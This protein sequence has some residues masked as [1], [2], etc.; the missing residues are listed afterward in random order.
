MVRTRSSV[1]RAVAGSGPERTDK[2]APTRRNTAA[3]LGLADE[4]GDRLGNVYIVPELVT[5][6]SLYTSHRTG[7]EYA[8]AASPGGMPVHTAA[9]GNGQACTGDRVPT[10]ILFTV[11][12]KGPGQ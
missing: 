4:P 1:E 8:S 2:T 6:P 7:H 5:G 3:L 11:T 12:E 10:R 9:P